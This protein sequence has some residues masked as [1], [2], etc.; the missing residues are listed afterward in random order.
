MISISYGTLRVANLLILTIL[1]LVLAR[2]GFTQISRLSLIFL[3]PVVFLLGPTLIGYVEEEGYTYYPYVLI[4][5]SI[6]PQ[7]L[8]H[9]KK[10]KF[11]YWF[12][13]SILFCSGNYY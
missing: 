1:N 6:I 4:C 2:Y 12:S 8:L 9:P 5:V 3:P 10:E 7:L 11:L 13:L